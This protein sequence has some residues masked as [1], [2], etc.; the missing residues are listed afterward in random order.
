MVT[1][2]LSSAFAATFP[3]GIKRD[4]VLAFLI[5]NSTG[6]DKKIEQFMEGGVKP[7]LKAWEDEKKLNEIIEN[8]SQDP[9]TA[10]IL[11]NVRMVDTLVES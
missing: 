11:A 6:Q 5:E 10:P 3:E 9:L 4:E 8:M 1:P 7:M 2:F